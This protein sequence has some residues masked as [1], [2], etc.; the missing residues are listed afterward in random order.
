MGVGEEIPAGACETL[1]F[2]T[3]EVA[4]SWISL[5]SGEIWDSWFPN[6]ARKHHN[7]VWAKALS[8]SKSNAYIRGSSHIPSSFPGCKCLSRRI[9]HQPLPKK[10]WPR[11]HEVFAIVGLWVRGWRVVSVSKINHE[12]SCT[13]QNKRCSSRCKRHTA[14]NSVIVFIRIAGWHHMFYT[15]KISW[16]HCGKFSSF[17]CLCAHVRDLFSHAAG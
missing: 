17:V 13:N 10:Q 7:Y 4:K 5:I 3:V 8:L 9:L 6:V 11:G 2:P 15:K 14:A 16:E 12:S 1:M